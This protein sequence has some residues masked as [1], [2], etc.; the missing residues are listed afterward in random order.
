[1]GILYVGGIRPNKNRRTGTARQIYAPIPAFLTLPLPAADGLSAHPIVSEGERVLQGQLIAVSD[2]PRI[3][4]LHAP[5]SGKIDTVTASDPESGAPGVIRIQN[6]ERMEC[7]PSCQPFTGKLSQT[8][9]ETLLSFI[10][11]TGLVAPESDCLSLAEHLRAC[12]G[13]V[14]TVILGGVDDQP[15]GGYRSHLLA[16]EPDR[17]LAGMKLVMRILGVKNGVIAIGN[18]QYDAIDALSESLGDKHWLKMQTVNPIYPIS[19][20]RQLVLA[21]FQ[22]EQKRGQ[23]F[24]DTGYAVFPP[25]ILFALYQAF[26]TGM[27]LIEQTVMIDGDCTARPLAVI[28]P[29]GISVAEVFDT[30]EDWIKKPDRLAC[31]FGALKASH[32]SEDDSVGK[33]THVLLALSSSYTKKP[34]PLSILKLSRFQPPADETACIGCGKCMPVCPSELDIPSM[35]SHLEND[36]PEAI[37]P[38]GAEFCIDCGCCSYVCPAEI[39]VP[40]LLAAHVPPAPSNEPLEQKIE[41]AQKQIE[42]E[43]AEAEAAQNKPETEQKKPEA[44]QVKPQDGQNKPE[45]AQ[46]KPQGAQNKPVAAQVKPQ[47]AQN[48]PESAQAKPEAAQEKP[49]AAQAKP[50]T[51]QAKAEA[52]QKQ[53]AA[54]TDTKTVSAPDAKGGPTDE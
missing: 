10:E 3:A 1:M 44:A 19:H 13:K 53:A 39:N 8:D 22:K 29:I 18:D 24:A 4:S 28:A 54:Q 23:S 36:R 49:V 47:D 34:S 33:G 38:L 30:C 31:G 46:V 42:A 7:H 37:L 41:A 43:Q 2:S 20:P 35:L 9:D 12:R 32:L 50:E 11:A 27:P 45:A 48:K 40:A 21:L 16:T 51:A 25:D 5:V 17:I 52:D 26:A 6:D 14:H 15:F